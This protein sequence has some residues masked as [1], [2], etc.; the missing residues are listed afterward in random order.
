[1]NQQKVKKTYI[2]KGKRRRFTLHQRI[3]EFKLVKFE[4]ANFLLA[5]KWIGNSGSHIGKLESK[6]ILV[7]Y[8]LLEHTL[9]KLFDDKD[10][11]LKKKSKE[12]NQRRGIRKK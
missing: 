3:E 12:I 10:S 4:I 9:N 5:I 11:E 8:E 7:A 2:Q 6:D 1:M